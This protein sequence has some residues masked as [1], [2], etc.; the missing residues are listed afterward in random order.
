MKRGKRTKKEWIAIVAAI[1]AAILFLGIFLMIE[2]KVL[3]SYQV[4]KVVTA[5]KEIE[6]GTQITE[7]N[8]AELFAVSE[9]PS[10]CIIEDA[11][12][13]PEELVGNVLN[14]SVHEKEMV[15]RLDVTNR[16]EWIGTMAEPIEFTFS[17]SSISAA[18]A[19]SIRGG[20]VIDIGITY[21]TDTSQPCYEAVGRSVYVKEV[22]NDSGK[23][24]DRADKD[25]PCTMFRVVME[26]L[27]G[28]ALMERLRA[29]DEVI[30][31]LP[32]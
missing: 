25:T 12:L 8:V 20:D 22:Y 19:G 14:Q 1:V 9:F 21:Q 5:K 13:V 15:S 3:S 17:A 30:V 18:V 16:Q 32:K 24:I 29:G 4:Q 23:V 27:E 11:F 28:E 7:E 2:T 10:E 26:K 31:T 6:E